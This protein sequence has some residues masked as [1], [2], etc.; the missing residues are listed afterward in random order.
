[1]FKHTF[2]LKNEHSEMSSSLFRFFRAGRASAPIT[3][4]TSL[5]RWT[6]WPRARG[7]EK[8]VSRASRT[9]AKGDSTTDPPSQ[10]G[11]GKSEAARS[12]CH[13]Y[14]EQARW[15]QFILALKWNHIR[16][17]HAIFK[18]KRDSLTYIHTDV[19]ITNI[20]L[21]FQSKV[22]TTFSSSNDLTTVFVI[23][24]WSFLA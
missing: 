11:E 10:N 20:C 7:K 24:V 15:S 3:F 19:F 4:R 17:N 6:L 16:L 1:M 23:L 13:F 22:H 5:W 12:V 8:D 9:M 14:T 21:L 2:L 18:R